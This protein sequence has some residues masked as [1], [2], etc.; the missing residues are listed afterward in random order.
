ML[1]VSVVVVCY[2]ERSNIDSC[3][4]SLIRQ[5]YS[6]KHYEVICIDNG[7][8]DGTQDILQDFCRRQ[9]HIKWII[10][11]VR[12]I[13]GS[14][15]LGLANSRYDHVA[16]IDADCIAPPDWLLE[17][18]TGFEL[19]SKGKPVCAGVGGSNVPP[20]T[21]RFYEGLG[22]FLKSYWGNHGSVQGKIYA[23]DRAVPHLPTVNVMYSKKILTSVG[24]FDLSFGNIGE[25]QDLSYRLAKNGYRLYYL[26]KPTVV[27]KLRPNFLSWLGNMF[28]YGKGRMWLMRKHPDKIR[29]ILLLPLMLVLSL[30]AVPA[31]FYS[32]FFLLPLFY[33]IIIFTISIYECTKRNKL[34]LFF[35]VY[36]L[37]VGTHIA[38]GLGQWYGLVNNRE[39]GHEHVHRE[40]MIN[41]K[42]ADV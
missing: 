11:P 3:L 14:R 24:G 18:S 19:Y 7:S 38:Y 13:A 12:G 42:E 16:F 21:S 30:T 23:K 17:L 2:N 27:H 1:D 40:L 9:S 6:K 8:N 36:R 4:T 37:Y 33:F 26:S 28:T 10:N 5:K 29:P 25:D 15:N 20:L 31:A 32:S 39:Y 22:I 41:R 34:R 35:Q